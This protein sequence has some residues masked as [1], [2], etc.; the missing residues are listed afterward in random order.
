MYAM[1]LFF[2]LL[3]F[4][5]MLTQTGSI[6][7]F[8]AFC[9]CTAILPYIHYYTVFFILGEVLYTFFYWFRSSD[10]IGK[11][12]IAFS[13][14]FIFILTIPIIIYF[15]KQRARIVG[16]WFQGQSWAS[17]LST[18]HYAFFHVNV[19]LLSDI[20]SVLGLIFVCVVLALVLILYICRLE[21]GEKK[22]A[23]WLFLAYA[24]PPFL[25]MAI[26]RLIMPVYH[27][28]FFFF[29]S[30]I[31]VLLVGRAICVLMSDGKKLGRIVGILSGILV[32]F[33]VLFNLQ[34]YF[35]TQSFEL[36][37]TN[38]WLQQQCGDDVKIV[39]HESPF[40]MLPGMVL[41][42]CYQHYVYSELNEK[43]FAS[44]GGDV[45]NKDQIISNKTELLKFDKFYYMQSEAGSLIVPGF[46]YETMFVTDGLNVTLATRQENQ[47]VLNSL[48]YSKEEYLMSLNGTCRMASDCFINNSL[49]GCEQQACNWCC[50]ALGMLAGC[51]L[52]YCMAEEEVQ[53]LNLT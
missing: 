42:P 47:S 1:A 52:M 53:R 13:W 12:K 50:N 49:A 5:L 16:M 23:L 24:I 46:D 29:T 39:I 32:L 48:G 35:T 20:S 17:L 21:G 3:S 7:K 45:I 51:T 34:V 11:K 4:Y 27:H 38:A 25:G 26:N 36:R 41:A 18:V 43:E 44:A 15:F 31:L 2:C 37:D 8:L 10:S 28:R 6:L 40:S 33:F 14:M 30:W 9:F 22:L 19:N